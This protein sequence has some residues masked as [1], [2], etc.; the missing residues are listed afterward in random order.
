MYLA[1]HSGK[2]ASIQTIADAFGIS[3]HHLVKVVHELGKHQFLTTSRGRGGGVELGR[4]PDMISIGDVV[5]KMEPHLTIV[6][7]F[8]AAANQCPLI[9]I[10]LLQPALERARDAFLKI[11]DEVTLA[12]VTVN[13]GAL[14]RALARG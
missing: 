1:S 6:E 13:G 2:K 3:G 9:R 5:R 12:D 4:S 8:D 14:E 11:L 10:C 7:C